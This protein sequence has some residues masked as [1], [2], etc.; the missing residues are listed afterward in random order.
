MATPP[1]THNYY[2]QMARKLEALSDYARNDPKINPKVAEHLK[3]FAEDI[4]K[5]VTQD[6]SVAPC[7]LL[8]NALAFQLSLWP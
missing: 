8:P 5:D 4:L 2:V 7:A 1:N 3:S 6:P